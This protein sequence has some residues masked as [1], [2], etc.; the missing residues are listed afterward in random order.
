MKTY[1]NTSVFFEFLRDSAYPYTIIDFYS[2]ILNSFEYLGTNRQ[3]LD[4]IT[5]GTEYIY[6]HDFLKINNF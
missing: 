3:A 6:E 5:L 4:I 2:T 1:Y